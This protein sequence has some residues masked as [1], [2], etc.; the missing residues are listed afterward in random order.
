MRNKFVALMKRLAYK[1]H[2][3]GVAIIKPEEEILNRVRPSSL[4]L[5]ASE[6]LLAM[7]WE[8]EDRG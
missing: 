1:L 4:L 3:A 6:E 8:I 2:H 7:A 5:D